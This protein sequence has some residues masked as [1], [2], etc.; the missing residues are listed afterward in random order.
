[1]LDVDAKKTIQKSYSG[2]LTAKSLKPRYGQKLMIAEIARSLGKIHLDEDNVNIAEGNVAVVE[3]GTGTGKTVAYLLAALPIAIALEKRVVLST[4]T[5][6]LQEQVTIKDI[7]DVLRHSGL[8][9]SYALAKGRGRYLCLSKLERILSD[10]NDSGPSLYEDE[11]VVVNQEELGLY[12]SMLQKTADGEWDGDRDSWRDEVA[13]DA[14]QRITTDHRQ[15]AGRKCSNIR[16][17]AFYNARNALEDA[18]LIVANH[19]LVLADLALGGGAILPAP[20]DSIYIFD[21][22]H[23]L[24][25]KALNHFSAHTRYRSSIRWLGQSEGQWP[26]HLKPVSEL[27]YFSQ[28]SQPLEGLLKDTRSVLEEALPFVRELCE[29]IDPREFS[30]K[31]Q[32]SLGEVSEELEQLAQKAS[33]HFSKLNELI[34]KLYKEIE[35]IVNEE[36]GAVP[37]KDAESMMLLLGGWLSRSEANLA[38]WQSYRSTKFDEKYPMARWITLVDAGDTNDYEFVSSPVLASGILRGGLWSRCCGAVVTSATMRALNSFDRFKLKSGL[39]DET[40]FVAVPSPFDYQSNASLHIPANA[41]EANKSV[42]HTESLIELLPEIIDAESATLVLFSSHAQMNQVLD[43]MPSRLAA[44]IHCQGRESKQMIIERHKQCVDDGEGSVIWGLASFAEGVDL[45]GKYCE[46]V[47]IAKIPF[48]VPDE[49][50]EAAY[51]EWIEARGGNAFM[52]V[53]VPDASTK[54]IQACGRLLRTE[55]DTGKIT[56]LDKR[57]LSKRYGKA[58]LG[59]L[60][61]FKMAF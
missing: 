8:K 27:T 17:C 42:E 46:H 61:P 33:R 48:S 47:I 59:S 37:Q 36:A 4:A 38:L 29:D 5:V 28:L 39:D 43:A 55:T 51:S 50:L 23:H 19:D 11:I 53:S 13:S 24:P 25:E 18:D 60:P 1:M 10:S 44:K 31:K 7:P 12:R 56:I 14:W 40:N 20:E 9:F 30:P 58:I 32:F 41:V 16:D 52:E 3:A 35:T 21:E 26:N 45:P 15:C 22:G 49:P 57:L 54:L 2:F 6:A 34:D